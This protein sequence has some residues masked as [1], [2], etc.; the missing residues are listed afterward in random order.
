MGVT[1]QNKQGKMAQDSAAKRKEDRQKNVNDCI[2]AVAQWQLARWIQD[3]ESGKSNDPK[4][5]QA[6]QVHRTR[7]MLELRETLELR[8]QLQRAEEE[9]LLGRGG[10]GA[11]A[12][13]STQKRS[14]LSAKPTETQRTKLKEKPID[15]HEVD[16]QV[17]ALLNEAPQWSPD[18][19]TSSVA[20]TSVAAAV[21][22]APAAASVA[23]AM[24]APTAASKGST[25]TVAGPQ[26]QAQQ[27]METVTVN[28]FADQIAPLLIRFDA[29]SS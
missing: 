9:K 27:P 15:R 17:L 5:W 21:T 7:D 16:R 2:D 13:A 10:G 25:L 12:A 3:L 6:E 28:R 26:R 4:V 14:A 23:P 11:T 29:I 8:L 19:A 24:V 20:A 22:A 1:L 18:G